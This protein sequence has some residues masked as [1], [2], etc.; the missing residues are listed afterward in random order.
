MSRLRRSSQAVALGLT[1]LL[2]ATAPDARA[3]ETKGVGVYHLTI[4]WGE[5]PAFSGSRN[6]VEVAVAD[7]KGAPVA[8]IAGPLSVEI[9]FGEKR[10]V[11]PLRPAAGQPGKFRAPIVP[12]RPGTY[13]FRVA[14]RVKGQSIDIRSTCSDTTFDCVTDIAEVQF[15]AKDP[16]AGDLADGIGRALPRADR[17]MEAAASARNVAISAAV[18]GTLALAAAIVLGLRKGAKAA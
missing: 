12:T 2:L 1:T 5:E 6:F 14:G 16:S 9:T 10:V 3:H 11:L 18:V 17:A 13:T 15:P 4:G 8:D 7:A